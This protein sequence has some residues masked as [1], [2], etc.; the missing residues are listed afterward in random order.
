MKNYNDPENFSYEVE[1][2]D[3]NDK[4]IGNEE[5]DEEKDGDYFEYLEN[6]LYNEE[7]ESEENIEDESAKEQ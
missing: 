3:E 6:D 2:D 5:E 1:E 4:F 7:E